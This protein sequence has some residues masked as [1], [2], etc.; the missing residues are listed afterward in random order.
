MGKISVYNN[1]Y[2]NME[3]L[4]IAGMDVLVFQS[5][6]TYVAVITYIYNDKEYSIKIDNCSF[7]EA[8][9]IAFT[10]ERV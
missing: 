8:K 6:D 5:T 1:D 9:E 4:K 10:I 3:Q 2:D 7:D